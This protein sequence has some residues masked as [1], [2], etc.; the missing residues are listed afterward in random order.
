[1]PTCSQWPTVESLASLNN[2][3]D[4]I[5]GHLPDPSTINVDNV[6]GN[7]V[8]L[9]LGGGRFRLLCASTEKFRQVTPGDE[10][11]E[12]RGSWENWETQATPRLRIFTFML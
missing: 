7:H 5:P 8:V 2:L 12:G 11:K 3:D 6:D 9:D 10:C 1:V 4:P